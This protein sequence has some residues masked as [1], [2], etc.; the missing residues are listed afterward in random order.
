M[1]TAILALRDTLRAYVADHA[2]QVADFCGTALA[3][4]HATRDLAPRT[5]PAIA[6][7]SGFLNQTTPKLR[8]LVQAIV[9]AAPSLCWQHSYSTKDPGINADFLARSGWFN[10]IAPSGPFVSDSL[11][12][13]IGL[14][15]KGL[16][17]PTHWHVPEEI[18]LTIAGAAT[19]HSQGRTPVRAGPGALVHHHSNQPH[20]ATMQ[21][22][23]L[24]AAAFWRGHGL[25]DISTLA[26]AQPSRE[27]AAS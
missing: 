10:L 1:E 19:Y 16:H 14:W 2:P 9:E 6:G 26:P 23:P 15:G 4:D 5:L 24:L 17:Y 25:E 22:A 7:L 21:D 8:P 12:V 27:G 3:N 18:Y 13:S 11:R 20:A